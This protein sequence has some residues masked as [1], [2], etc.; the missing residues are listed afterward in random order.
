MTS[1][2]MTSRG[3]MMSA[4]RDRWS[5]RSTRR[6]TSSSTEMVLVA[7]V[8]AMSLLFDLV[9]GAILATRMSPRV[10]QTQY[11]KLRGVRVTLSNRRLP[12]VDAYLGL[13]Y[14]SLLGGQRLRFMPPTG[15]TERWEGVRVALRYRPVC[16]QPLPPRPPWSAGGLH[17][18]E[19]PR[20]VDVSSFVEQQSEDC[21]NLNVYIPATG[22]LHTIT[23]SDCMFCTHARS[24]A[25]YPS[26]TCHRRRRWR[27]LGYHYKMHTDYPYASVSDALVFSFSPTLQPAATFQDHVFSRRDPAEY[28]ATKLGLTISSFKHSLKLYQIATRAAIDKMPPVSQTTDTLCSSRVFDVLSKIHNL[29]LRM[30]HFRWI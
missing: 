1:R 20:R 17:Q 19:R 15:T 28:R 9:G 25:I 6:R 4:A 13:Q 14:A 2:L 29:G 7:G 10:V 5:R 3:L 26:L 12:F 23:H 18:N 11:G 27:P 16:P 21:L 30:F 24:L 8:I 22:S